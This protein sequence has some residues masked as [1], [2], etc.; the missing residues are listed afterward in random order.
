MIVPTHDPWKAGFGKEER[1]SKAG[2][3]NGFWVVMIGFEIFKLL[4]DLKGGE[5]RLSLQ[6]MIT[7]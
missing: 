5:Y 7:N 3:L 4:A 6:K 2:M 1:D